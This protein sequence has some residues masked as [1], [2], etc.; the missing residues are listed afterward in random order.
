ML[1]QFSVFGFQFSVAERSAYASCRTE[2]ASIREAAAIF[3]LRTAQ[4]CFVDDP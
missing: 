3:N 4:L 2:L 1:Q